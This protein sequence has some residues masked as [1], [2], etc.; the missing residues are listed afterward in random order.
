MPLGPMNRRTFLRASGVCIG[1]PL[2]DAMLPIG[3]GA[4]QRAE[5]MRPKRLLLIGRPLGLYTPHFFPEK[6]GKD[7][8]LTRYLKPLQAFR[9]DFT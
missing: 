7:Y 3:R 8:Q 5:A 2:L 9:D 4:E 1:L 6:P